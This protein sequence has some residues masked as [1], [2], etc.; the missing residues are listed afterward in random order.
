MTTP[1]PRPLDARRAQLRTQGYTDD[2]ISRAFADEIR[3]SS[4]PQPQSAA[5]NSTVTGGVA[6]QGVMSGVLNNLSVAM[7]LATGFL[8]SIATDV[9][10]LI[11]GDSLH[12]RSKAGVYLAVKLALVTVIGFAI[13]Q[14][15][16]QHIISN[17]EIAKQQACEARKKVLVSSVT[18]DGGDS[19]WQRSWDQFRHDC[20]GVVPQEE[21]T[22]PEKPEYVWDAYEAMVKLSD[23]LKDKL[24]WTGIDKSNLV[25]DL[26]KAG[27]DGTLQIKLENIKSQ[28]S[29]PQQIVQ[30]SAL[31]E[32]LQV[33]I[34]EQDTALTKLEPASYDRIRGESPQ[35]FIGLPERSGQA[36]R[37]RR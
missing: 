11:G 32:A 5:A 21:V 6:G 36:T 10:N 3:Q 22:R 20:V 15:Y 33:Y 31:A 12:V 35:W 27:R 17:T 4:Q 2:E 26:V 34:E 24:N 18:M 9:T 37:A 25:S 8:P 19:A 13:Y 23:A 1:E 14:E 29:S 16:Q 28:L 7:A 30:L